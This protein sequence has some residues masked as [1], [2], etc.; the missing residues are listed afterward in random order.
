MGANSEVGNKRQVVEARRSYQQ[1]VLVNNKANTI[2]RLQ[3]EAPPQTA[4]KQ[5]RALGVKKSD[6]V[7][8][9]PSNNILKP[10]FKLVIQTLPGLFAAPR[11]NNSTNRDTTA[12]SIFGD[13]RLTK[14]SARVK[15]KLFGGFRQPQHSTLFCS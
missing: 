13:Y 8:L 11:A 1:K 15:E 3:N 12:F 14:I 2:H 6:I 5:T 7:V 9:S 4:L 10:A